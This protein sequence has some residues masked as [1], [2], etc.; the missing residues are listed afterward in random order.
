MRLTHIIFVAISIVA[1]LALGILLGARFCR[2]P[3]I[4]PTANAQG[5]VVN[6]NQPDQLGAAAFSV[7]QDGEVLYWWR[8]QSNGLGYVI[9]FD[10]R[11][12]SVIQKEFHR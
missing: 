4:I 2:V 10:S 7:S 9:T 3:Q 1:I 6:Q 11:T 5:L 8:V 12:G